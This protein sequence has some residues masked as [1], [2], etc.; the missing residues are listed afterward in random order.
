[1]DCEHCQK[2]SVPETVT[3]YAMDEL[4]ARQDIANRRSFVINVILILALILSWIGF[5]I[6]ENQFED[7]IVSTNQE[8]EQVADGDG[9]NSF[10]GGDFYGYTTEGQD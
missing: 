1:M 6:Y 4:A 5:F 7:S 2:K 9:D 3:R 10:I 8:V